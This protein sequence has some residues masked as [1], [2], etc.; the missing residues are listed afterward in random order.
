MEVIRCVT[1]IAPL[2]VFSLAQRDPSVYSTFCN[3]GYCV[4]GV[5]EITC[6]KVPTPENLRPL[7]SVTPKDY[8]RYSIRLVEQAGLEANSLNGVLSYFTRVDVIYRGRKYQY[9]QPPAPSVASG[10]SEPPATRLSESLAPSPLDLS[11]HLSDELPVPGPPGHLNGETPINH[12]VP[13]SVVKA[14]NKQTFKQGSDPVE[15]DSVAGRHEWLKEVKNYSWWNRVW[16]FSVTITLL[17]YQIS[18]QLIIVWRL[19]RRREINRIYTG[20]HQQEPRQR[21]PPSRPSNP[22][23]Q[24]EPTN[25]PPQRDSEESIYEE[26]QPAGSQH[27]NNPTIPHQEA[28]E[29]LGSRSPP[30]A[31]PNPPSREEMVLNYLG[32]LPTLPLQVVPQTPPPPPPVSPPSVHPSPR[33]PDVVVVESTKC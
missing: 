30:N 1:C 18:T 19:R 4:C 26:P 17:V 11:T 7:E 8:R 27:V 14:S 15:F 24:R 23:A 29:A 31:P 3:V 22:P 20:D 28:R 21:T 10:S 33:D 25:S 13:A 9:T 16:I 12:T 32:P 5:R 6:Y 2:F